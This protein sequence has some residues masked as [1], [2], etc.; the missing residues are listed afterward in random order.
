MHFRKP[1]VVLTLIT[2][3]TATAAFGV[4]MHGEESAPAASD[5]QAA[6]AQTN[7]ARFR[8][9]LTGAGIDPDSERGKRLIALDVH[10][11]SNP[12]WHAMMDQRASDGGKANPF[13]SDKR[14][15]PP[16]I[17]LRFLTD[18][19]ALAP[20]M[21]AQ[22]CAA[23]G[24]LSPANLMTMVK[25]MPLQGIDV[26]QDMLDA[27][28]SR[29][30]TPDTGEHYS[31]AEL[32]EMEGRFEVDLQ[33]EFEKNKFALP[34]VTTA[35]SGGGTT[36]PN[37]SDMVRLMTATML[38]MP[39]PLRTRATWAFLSPDKKPDQ[40]IGTIIRGVL[41]N[42]YPYVDETFDESALPAT[43]REHLPA[44]GA[45]RL[46]FKRLTVEGQWVNTDTPGDT[47]PYQQIFLNRHD[48]GVVARLT[49]STSSPANP[50]WTDFST[51]YGALTL[52]SQTVSFGDGLTPLAQLE[53]GASVALGGKTITEGAEFEFPAEQPSLHHVKTVRCKIGHKRPAAAVFASLT[54]DAVDWSCTEAVENGKD[55]RYQETWLYDYGIAV[56]ESVNDENGLTGFE[57]KKVSIEQ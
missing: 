57:I 54:G 10:L 53:D 15:I 5:V 22:V 28:A 9:F 16:A 52:R 1:I 3:L 23:G 24:G 37:G 35:S 44:D 47:G 25:S 48:N 33:K 51:Q 41:V 40:A 12:A 26:L 50:T 32:L 38:N 2:S 56:G 14:G 8:A 29:D 31:T 18:L 17:R 45:R 27:V 34:G 13:Y 39:E 36:P 11:A 42:P 30:A 46:P 4:G 49:V 20:Y 43:F 19:A 6:P 7:D 21:P 55:R